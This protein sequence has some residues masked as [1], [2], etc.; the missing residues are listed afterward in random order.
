YK[1]VNN[2]L[3]IGGEQCAIGYSE[4]DLNTRFYFEKD[5]EGNP[6][7]WFKTGDIVTLEDNTYFYH[8][9]VDRQFKHNGQLICPEEIEY[10]AYRCGANTAKVTYKDKKITL[11]YNGENF[12]KLKLVEYIPTWCI[13]HHYEKVDIQ[14]NKNWKII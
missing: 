12:D 1:I 13:P 3:H 4:E 8:G 14:V 9:R 11:K 10:A 7:K 5:N 2:E 6:L